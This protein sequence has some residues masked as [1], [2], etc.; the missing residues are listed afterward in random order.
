[1]ADIAII[2][3]RIVWTDFIESQLALTENSSWKFRQKT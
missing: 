2:A 1:M 3:P